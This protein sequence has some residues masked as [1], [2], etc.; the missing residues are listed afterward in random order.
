MIGLVAAT[1]RGRALAEHVAAAWPEARL[2]PGSPGEALTAAWAGCDSVVAFL[3]TGAAMRLAAPLLRDKES[4]PGLVCVDDAARYAVALCGGHA[5]G[6]NRLAERV[7][8]LL[9]ATPVVTTASDA[10]GLPALDS[11]GADL[12]FRIAPGSDLAAVAAAI[13]AG[14]RVAF[15]SD[16]RWPLPPLPG[17][18]VPTAQPVPPCIIVSDRLVT[19]PRPAVVYRPPTLVVGV[20]CSRGAEAS[21]IL[22]LIDAALAEARLAPES[23]AALASVN[24]KADEAGLL[25]AA[26]ERGWPLRF[27]EPEV[28]ATIGV[29]NPSPVV[30]RAVGTPS[31]AEAAAL[32]SGGELVSAKRTSARVTVAVA[33]RAPR[34]RLFLVSL[35]PGDTALVPERARQALARAEL[36]VGLERYVE[37]ARPLL[38]PGTRIEA[39]AI[40]QEQARACRAVA[41]ARSGRSVALV[42]GGD[43]GVYAMASPALEAAAADIEVTVVPGITA[44][45]AAAALLGAPLGH[46]HCAISLSD[47]LTPWEVIRRRIEL[48]A[49]ADFAIAFYNPRS[50]ARDWQLVEAREILLAHRAAATPVGLVADA[51]RPEQ[52]VELTT[53]AELDPARVGMTSIVLVGSSQTRVV[54]GRMVTPRGY[55]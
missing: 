9:G 40:G 28:L 42:S 15:F 30:A 31:V 49:A 4:D 1:A 43:V 6:A 52:R 51:F 35:G 46:D 10:L 50:G 32:A 26:A 5:G 7:A 27:Y 12:G 33:R 8:E 38:R 36:V 37:Q 53:L 20:G 41:E 45:Q 18:V 24:R 54:A 39:S 55:R 19:P 17:N 11:L 48:A 3:A 22:E 21:E 44:A 2:F 13:V 25:A 16:Q 29:P 47:L 14:E 34:G 23:V